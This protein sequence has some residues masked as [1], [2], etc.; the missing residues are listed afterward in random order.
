M[1]KQIKKISIAWIVCIM[2]V[3]GMG[4][5]WASPM[6]PLS[7]VI[8]GS[9]TANLGGFGLDASVTRTG[10]LYH[11]E[12]V[13]SYVNAARPLTTFSVGNIGHHEFLRAGNDKPTYFANDPVYD[14]ADPSQDSVLWVASSPMPSS[15][16]IR[17][18]YESPNS[19][20]VVSVS[21]SGGGKIAGGS[22]L[23]M[24]P[25]PTSICVTATG[26]VGISTTFFRRFKRRRK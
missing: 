23:G 8:T 18:W 3:H 2:M 10:G 5:A 17:F 1:S 13:L 20:N 14:P 7:G 19:Y 24:V 9:G 15:N 25:E 11:Y 21:A 4:S 6:N 12:Y 26:L 22:T 16:T